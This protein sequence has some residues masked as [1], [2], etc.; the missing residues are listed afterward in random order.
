MI[1]KMFIVIISMFFFSLQTKEAILK[2]NYRKFLSSKNY[3]N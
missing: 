1:K 3:I 2:K